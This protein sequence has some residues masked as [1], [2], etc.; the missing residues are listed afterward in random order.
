ML[1]KTGFEMT[2]NQFNIGLS[3]ERNSSRV[4]RPPGGGHSDIFG[5]NDNEIAITPHKRRNHPQSTIGSCF[6]NG[7]SE[8]HTKLNG[9]EAQIEENGNQKNLEEEEKTELDG[10]DENTAPEEITKVKEPE[11]VEKIPAR[12]GRVPPGGY[13]TALW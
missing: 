10:S 8:P 12:N 4:L 7:D 6:A 2:S 5:I 3:S 13:S 11:K 1:T 9:S